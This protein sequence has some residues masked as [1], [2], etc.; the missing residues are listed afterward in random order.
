MAS[1]NGKTT[2][3]V[4][5]PAWRKQL[6]IER[7]N[8][9]KSQQALAQKS[10]SFLGNRQSPRIFDASY[11]DFVALGAR[12]YD[13]QLKMTGLLR[14]KIALKNVESTGDRFQWNWARYHSL[15][16]LQEDGIHSIELK[17]Y[18]VT[19]QFI[20]QNFHKYIHKRKSNFF[21][22]GRFFPRSLRRFACRLPGSARAS[23]R[24]RRPG[25]TEFQ[26]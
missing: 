1:S 18:I 14:R 7:G 21:T 4:K 24:S 9:A 16:R 20:I 22:H 2:P 17:M 11:D 25:C 13:R 5:A 12:G 23:A 6:K 3:C 15:Q 10:L 8:Y 26:T 19:A